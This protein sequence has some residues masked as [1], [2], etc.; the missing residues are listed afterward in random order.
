MSRSC[1]SSPPWRLHAVA[2]QLYFFLHMIHNSLRKVIKIH[3]KQKICRILFL[4]Y[5]ILCE[6]K[7]AVLRNN[8]K[9]DNNSACH[10]LD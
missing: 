4:A 10:F 3:I 8:D 6:V 5:K 2:G 1:T 7:R 9:G